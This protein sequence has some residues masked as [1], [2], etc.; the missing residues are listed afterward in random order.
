MKHE[1]TPNTKEKRFRE[2]LGFDNL[3][4]KSTGH[5]SIIQL[6]FTHRVLLLT[7]GG[8]VL[9]VGL[10]FHTEHRCLLDHL[11]TGPVKSAVEFFGMSTFQ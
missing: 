3:K 6:Q 10:S 9:Q 4:K 7:P 5:Y 11:K 1:S 8:P 2:Y